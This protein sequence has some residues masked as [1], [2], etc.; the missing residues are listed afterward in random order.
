MNNLLLI[1][2]I[3]TFSNL[4][5]AQSV[6]TDA[7]IILNPANIV[8]VETN[9]REILSLTELAKKPYAKLENGTLEITNTTNLQNV[10]FKGGL[11]IEA[12]VLRVYTGGQDGGGG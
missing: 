9:S 12:S 7:K 1:T 2:T 8:S 10:E 11:V 4:T 6:N 3:L 5:L